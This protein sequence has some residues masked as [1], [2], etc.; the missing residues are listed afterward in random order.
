MQFGE[1]Q[2]LLLLVDAV[3]RTLEVPAAQHYAEHRTSGLQHPAGAERSQQ[4][5]VVAD[6]VN[7]GADRRYSARRSME[8]AGRA[9]LSSSW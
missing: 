2:C 9:Q 6:A 4:D 7:E 1:T 8:P 5:G 3:D